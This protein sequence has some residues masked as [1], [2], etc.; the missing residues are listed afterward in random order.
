[1]ILESKTVIVTGV[2]PG[3]G[4]E[5]AKVALRDGANV[6]IGA[7]NEEKLKK[8]AEAL[9]PSG[10]RLAYAAVD[11][12]IPEQCDAIVALAKERFASV[13]VLIQA[14]AYEDCFGGLFDSDLEKW[15][16]AFNTNVLGTVTLLRSVVKEMK[17]AG[18]GSIVLIGSQAMYAPAVEQPGYAA[19][20]GALLSTMR[21]LAKE[22]GPDGIRVN[23][24]LPSWMWGPNVQ[25]FVQ[26]RAQSENKTEEEILKEITG[27]FPL[28]RMA[29][30]EE[31]A[32][33]VAFFAS[34]RASAITGQY[35]LVNCGEMMPQ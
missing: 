27:N 15:K 33:A 24:V 23:H 10:E 20:K 5:I 31:V 26:Y 2:G 19:S 22:L 13:D 34:D 28:R 21:Y 9:D 17:V 11:I 14:A 7:R 25:A 35:L 18:K 6:V 8:I 32:E 16:N 12:N 30:D 4:S 29:A 1:M 3:V